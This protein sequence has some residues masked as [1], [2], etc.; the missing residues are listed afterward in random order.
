M[1]N[2]YFVLAIFLNPAQLGDTSWKI[3]QYLAKSFNY[4]KIEYDVFLISFKRV[5]VEEK[6]K[7]NYLMLSG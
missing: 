3:I 1:W 7:E 6:R 2:F 4:N 5:Q